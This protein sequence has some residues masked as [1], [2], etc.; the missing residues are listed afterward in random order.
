MC[1][2][3][4]HYS[5][6]QIAE[7]ETDGICDTYR[8]GKTCLQSF[9]GKTEYGNKNLTPNKYDAWPRFIRVVT[10]HKWWAIANTV[11]NIREFLECVVNPQLLTRDI[12]P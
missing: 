11:M 4:N 2:R 8:G 10:G 3:H 5:G 6:N 1:S 9:R 12:A 7:D